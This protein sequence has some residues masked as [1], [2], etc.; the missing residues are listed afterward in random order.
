MYAI[1]AMFGIAVACSAP[2][3]Q[4]DDGWPD[5]V[6]VQTFLDPRHASGALI[7][8]CVVV[9]HDTAQGASVAVSC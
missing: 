6:R 8:Y 7:R 4:A 5:G 1:L 2:Q 3:P 9:T